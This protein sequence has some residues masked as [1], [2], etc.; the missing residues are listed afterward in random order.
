MGTRTLSASFYHIF[1][2]QR[3][4]FE[5]CAKM[6][7]SPDGHRGCGQHSRQQSDEGTRHALCLVHLCLEVHEAFFP[8][9][10]SL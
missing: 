4:S 3:P 10:C 1:W 5:R 2:G 7:K 8:I 9:G 6:H